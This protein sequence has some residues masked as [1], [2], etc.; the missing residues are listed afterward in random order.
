MPELPWWVE[1][2]EAIVAAADPA[3]WRG[4]A[5]QYHL[6]REHMSAERTYQF[7]PDSLEAIVERVVQVFEVEVTHKHDPATWASVVTEHFRTNVNG[8]TWATP[9]DIVDVG[10]YNL[11]IG[12]NVFYP[13]GESFDSSHDVFHNAL[14]EGFFWEVLEVLAGPPN[15]T[16]KWRHWGR[17]TGA[18]MGVEPTGETVEMFGMTHAKVGDDLRLLQVEHYY[19]PNQ[20]LSKLAGGCPVARG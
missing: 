20:L 14:P 12:D 11:F 10:S 17:F 5:P 18:Y 7:E 6:S 4:E 15:V 19:D 16:F 2:R 3:E 1:G 13:A 9:A 8:G